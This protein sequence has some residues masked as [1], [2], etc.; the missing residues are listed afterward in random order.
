MS[1]NINIYGK[2]GCEIFPNC[3]SAIL[4]DEE[5]EDN[6]ADIRMSFGKMSSEENDEISV[7]VLT[8]IIINERGLKTILKRLIDLSGEYNTKYNVDI[9]QQ[10]LEEYEEVGEEDATS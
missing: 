1:K 5:A 4:M 9:L 8:D 6:E 2:D 7:E 3:F 10:I